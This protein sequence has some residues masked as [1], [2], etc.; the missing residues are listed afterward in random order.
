VPGLPATAH[1][2]PYERMDPDERERLS[3]K[4]YQRFLEH[5]RDKLGK[6]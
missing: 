6:A 1:E 5:W 3:R 4:N 2:H